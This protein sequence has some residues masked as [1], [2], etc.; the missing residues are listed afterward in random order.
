MMA[1]PVLFQSDIQ[2][3]TNTMAT[4]ALGS[5][6]AAHYA[7]SSAINTGLYVSNGTAAFATGDGTVVM[8]ITYLTLPMS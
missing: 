1:G 3:T 5:G 2:G 7:S 4:T 6:A 8:Y